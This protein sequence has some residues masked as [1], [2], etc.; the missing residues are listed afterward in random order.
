MRSTSPKT[1]SNAASNLAGSL[2]AGL[3]HLGPAAA[4]AA[5]LRRHLLDEVARFQACNQ[6]LRHD[7]QQ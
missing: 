5:D 7:D 4:R 3:R 6:V 1:F 2:P